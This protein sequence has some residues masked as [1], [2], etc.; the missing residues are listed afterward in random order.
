MYEDIR[1]THRIS[2]KPIPKKLKKELVEKAKEYA[3]YKAFERLHISKFHQKI[4]K[5]KNNTFKSIFFLPMSLFEEVMEDNKSEISD[6]NFGPPSAKYDE[7]QFL[8]MYMEQIFHLMPREQTEK[9]KLISGLK[10]EIMKK[11]IEIQ[12]EEAQG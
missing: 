9:L 7:H 2:R 10:D 6:P 1:N 11:K 4:E 12:I 8:A 3:D 5:K